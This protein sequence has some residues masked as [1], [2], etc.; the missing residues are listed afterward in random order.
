MES[1]PVSVEGDLLPS[2]YMMDT[3]PG[4]M[5]KPWGLIAFQNRKTGVAQVSENR[6]G[7]YKLKLEKVGG[8]HI[9]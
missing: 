3:K 7:W 9:M 4:K 1:K 5:W 6:Q 2:E 8:S